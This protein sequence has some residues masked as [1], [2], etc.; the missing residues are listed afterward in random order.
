MTAY[1]AVTAQHF[2]RILAGQIV[3]IDRK[4]EGEAYC[5]RHGSQA[6]PSPGAAYLGF[7]KIAAKKC[8]VF[9]LCP[10]SDRQ[11]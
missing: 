11:T 3:F 10:N 1:L 8:R 4:K 2:T 9:G 6:K 7:A 5:L